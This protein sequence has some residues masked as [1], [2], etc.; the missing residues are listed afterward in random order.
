MAEDE[1]REL[2]GVVTMLVRTMAA[3]MTTVTA[4]TRWCAG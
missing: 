4:A 2:E 3:S 1:E